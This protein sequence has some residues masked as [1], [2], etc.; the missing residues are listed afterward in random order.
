MRVRRIGGRALLIAAGF[1]AVLLV[2]AALAARTATFREWLRHQIVA[3]LN[4][5]LNGELTIGAL[6][7]DLLRSLVVT[8]VRLR[9]EGRR[10]FAA[11]RVAARY[12]LVKLVTGRGLALRDVEIS[13]LAVRLVEDARGWNIARLYPPEPATPAERRSRVEVTLDGIRLRDASLKVVQPGDGWRFRDLAAAGSARVAG[14]GESLALDALSVTL[15]DRDVRVTALTGAFAIDA[16]G[17][18]RAEAVHLRTDGSD[19]RADARIPGPDG[20]NYDVSLEAE[21]LSAAEMRHLLRG[22]VP[23]TDLA[24]TVRVRGPAEWAALDGA[25]TSPAGGIAFEGNVG[26]GELPSYD[27]RARLTNL[28]A[29]GWLGPTR[30]ETD[31]TGTIGVKGKGATLDAAVASVVLALHDSTVDGR[32]ISQLSLEADVAE[33][34]VTFEAST[35]LEGGGAEASGTVGLADERYD[36][37]LTTRDFDPAPLLGRSDLRARLNATLALAG[38]GF[39]PDRARASARLTMTASRIGEIDVASAEAQMRAA[40]GTLTID[41]L[42]VDADAVQLQSSGTLALDPARASATGALRYQLRTQNLAPVARL[43]GIGPLA[44]SLVVDGTAS[45]GLGDLGIQATVTGRQVTRADTAV[46]T[47]VAHFA[48]TGLGGGRGHV[49]VDARAEDLHAVGRRFASLDLRGQWRQEAEG[50]AAAGA[51]LGVQED[52]RHRHELALDATLTARERRATISSLRLDLGDDTWRAE[53]TPVVTQRGARVAIERFMMRS[54]RGLL[55]IEGEGGS[56]GPQDVSARIEG[57]DLA[58][59]GAR[60]QAALAGRVS[61]TAHLGGSAQAP[62]LEAH[63]TITA[64]TI[65][66]VRYESAAVDVTVGGGRAVVSARVVQEGPRQLALEASSPLRLGFSP[67]AYEAAGTLAG[68]LRADA[69]DLAFLDPLVPQVSKL[70]GTLN[71]DLALGGTIAQPEVRGP[72]AIAGGH[73]YVVPVGLTY[74][75]IELRITLDGTAASIESVRIA[76]GK[77]TL[78][79]GGSARLGPDGAG[80]DARFQLDRFPLFANEFGDGT[81]SGWMWLAGT[82]AAPIVEGALTTDRLVLLVPE[83]L[84]GSVRPPDPTVTV[85]GPGAARVAPPEPVAAGTSPAS[86]GPTPG[87]YDRAAI[88]VQIDVPRN[89]WI[90]RSD[91]NIELRGWMTAWKKPSQE[92]ALAGVID[93]VRGW[94]SFQGKTFTLE[95]GRVSFSGQDFN[96]VLDLT[97]AYKTTDYTVRVKLGGTLTKPTLTLESEPALQQADVLSVLLFGKPASELNRGESMGLREQAI[98]V[99]SSYVASGLRQSVADTLGVDT[100]QFETGGQGVEGSTVSLG[101]YIAPD[102]F[103]SLAHRF[104]KQG[105]Q[106]IRV[107]YRVTPNWSIETSSDTLGESGVDV[108]WKRRY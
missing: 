89:A 104:A 94:Y 67:F 100:L 17:A 30:P 45:G 32:A 4:A 55:R 10:V 76:S 29:A 63:A 39:R 69:I 97:A 18:V 15:P 95:E 13:G 86:G 66:Q 68:T 21:H 33:R 106:E 25:I 5:D 42:R 41:A 16:A 50:R 80:M 103:V 36:V 47:L 70:G 28:N 43:A 7:G 6:D 2:V 92:P 9:S 57:L 93:T 64:P 8:D 58:P 75:A 79:G 52:A 99:A 60:V 87:V 1:A 85:I 83:S 56:A 105:A 72:L 102:V 26:S 101:K 107:E 77:G 51:A 11:R 49:D 62:E 23:T 46:G 44:G 96:P 38:T 65:E 108:F 3:R 24:A 19:V 98:G 37:R 54:S 74:D 91:T 14:D 82:T 31:L 78:T 88:T 34:Q 53:G 61:A 59:L 73:A 27:L 40:D 71:A 12:D 81:V 20:G 48:A 84:P 35:T 90:R 22:S